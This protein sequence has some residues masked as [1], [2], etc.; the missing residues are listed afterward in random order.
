MYMYV[1]IKPINWTQYI[2]K[3][4]CLKVKVLAL[5]N[6]KNSEYQCQG[7]STLLINSKAINK[8][9]KFKYLYKDNTA[10]CKFLT[11]FV[12]LLVWSNLKW[13]SSKTTFDKHI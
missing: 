5:E 13:S 8:I 9:V 4:H 1:T 12:S 3:Q 2:L 11:F 10:Y 6:W 7:I